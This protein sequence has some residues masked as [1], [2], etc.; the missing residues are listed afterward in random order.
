MS[1]LQK[2]KKKK[3]GEAEPSTPTLH[4]ATSSSVEAEPQ[5]SSQPVA[6]PPRAP[7]S[8]QRT[9][10]VLSKRRRGTLRP[11]TDIF[12]PTTVALSSSS[13]DDSP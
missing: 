9:Q 12:A 11:S 7:A 4:S 5:V 6:S 10:K 1:A 13:Q 8:A 2:S 3:S